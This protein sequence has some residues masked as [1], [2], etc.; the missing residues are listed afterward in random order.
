[1]NPLV[2]IAIEAARSAGRI[3][4]KGAERPDLIKVTEKNPDD[5]VTDIDQRAEQAIINLI[6][7]SYPQHAILAEESGMHGSSETVWIVDPL[8]GSR[9]FIHSCPHY[10]VSIAIQQAGKIEHGV[11]YD[12]LRD[13]LFVASAGA[14]ASL[15]GRRLRLVAKSAEKAF[16]ALTYPQ[17]TTEE[18]L[19]WAKK[20]ALLSTQCGGIRKMGSAVLDLAYLAAGRFDVC[21]TDRLK[22]WDFA[23]GALLVTEAG[24]LISNWQ[25]GEDYQENGQL[26]AAHPKLFKH[27]IK[28]VAQ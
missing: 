5:Y 22:L 15:N 20:I 10:A 8:D 2:S 7:K 9:N 12:P 17:P 16:I 6:Q 4:L 1:M 14:G 23:A 21:V 26:Y 18:A 19:S 3:I 28:T 27:F 13:E 25:G 11:V 24:G